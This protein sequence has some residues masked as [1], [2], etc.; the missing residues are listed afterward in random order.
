[1]R[2]LVSNFFSARH[3]VFG[4]GLLAFWC[5]NLVLVSRFG[6]TW[7]EPIVLNY[8]D[9]VWRY[10][11]S[12]DTGFLTMDDR[13]HGVWYSL[14]L[15]AVGALPWIHSV[16]VAY[17][18]QHGFNVTMY[19]VGGLGFYVML[20][21]LG[22]SRLYAGLGVVLLL[23]HPRLWGHAVTNPK[24]IPFMMI[25]VWSAVSMFWFH[26]RPSVKRGVVLGVVCGAA[27]ALRVVGGLIPVFW[28][29][30]FA[31]RYRQDWKALISVCLNSVGAVIVLWPYLWG[32]P[33][34]LFEAIEGM[35]RYHWEGTMLYRGD[36]VW[37]TDLPWHYSWTWMG[38]TTP[39]LYGLLLGIA[40]IKAYALLKRQVQSS[41][42]WSPK[43]MMV[44]V[45]AVVPIMMVSFG[46]AHLYDGWRHLF[47]VAP[48]WVAICTM[49]I[50][51]RLRASVAV[52]VCCGS[53][54]FATAMMFPYQSVYFNALAGPKETIRYRYEQDYWGSSYLECL[55]AILSIESRDTIHLYV[56]NDPGRF[57]ALLLP[58]ED[59][60]RFVF[61][62]NLGDA[63]YF[64]GNFRWH[65]RDY[66]PVRPLYAVERK[67]M[68]LAVVYALR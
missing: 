59:R 27:I 44:C 7:D 36:V 29:L 54:A 64:V 22:M 67:G 66:S 49:G 25:W 32:N 37:S 65:P 45:W 2:R 21:Q 52:L 61:V 18:W 42:T 17:L 9:A 35:S 33:L 60:Y 31:W 13:Y 68:Q 24:D 51:R 1:M 20:L 57:N 34:R 40:G 46:G 55:K 28:C 26:E 48:A 43:W 41:W 4:L 53:V 63:D 47:F 23:G 8:A 6:I 10:I 16:D 58:K 14:L 30:V 3:S 56:A 11:V 62:D 5:V 50:P 12:G 38:I 39:C 15:K 19:C